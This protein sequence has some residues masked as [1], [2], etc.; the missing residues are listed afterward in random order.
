MGHR[1]VE[2]SVHANRL[3]QL[4]LVRGTYLTQQWSCMH[5]IG[6]NDEYSNAGILW[7]GLND[8]LFE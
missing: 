4:L 2:G 8:N 5:S 3:E 7:V 6:Y 1:V